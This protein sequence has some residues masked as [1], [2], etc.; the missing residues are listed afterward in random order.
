MV[1]LPRIDHVQVG[2]INAN[3]EVPIAS[4]YQDQVCNTGQTTET[5]GDGALSHLIG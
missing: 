5:H 2:L 4:E 1:C 3:V